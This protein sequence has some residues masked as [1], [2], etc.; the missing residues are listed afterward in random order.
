MS[1]PATPEKPTRWLWWLIGVPAALI[2]LGIA[3]N[4]AGK[5]YFRHV[6]ETEAGEVIHRK[7]ENVEGVFEMRPRPQPQHYS[8]LFRKREYPED[9]HGYVFAVPGSAMMK[10]DP[11]MPEF[12]GRVKPAQERPGYTFV[13]TLNERDPNVGKYRF[14]RYDNYLIITDKNE[15]YRLGTSASS[16]VSRRSDPVTT[17]RSRY[18][19]TWSGL[20][21]WQFGLFGIM[22]GQTTILDLQ[23]NEVIA[24][25]KGFMRRGGGGCPRH[26]TLL[27]LWLQEVLV[28][29]PLK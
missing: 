29:A 11:R 14:Y 12:P 9:P 7:V 17:L 16:V 20:D 2:A 1:E 6:C 24:Y 3:F 10:G 23:T 22:G 19:F 27:D 8:D 4:Q 15:L 21:R 13:E 26:A 18:G 28:P 5:A 25:R